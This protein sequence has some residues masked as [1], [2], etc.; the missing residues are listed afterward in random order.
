M[1]RTFRSYESAREIYFAEY[2]SEQ[3]II[4]SA[5]ERFAQ[6]RTF[7]FPDLAFQNAVDVLERLFS[8]RILEL[9]TVLWSIGAAL[10]EIAVAAGYARRS[11]EDYNTGGR[12]DDGES[13][14]GRLDHEA[15]R[16]ESWAYSVLELDP[17]RS[18]MSMIKRAYKGLMLR[19]HPDVNPRGLDKAKEINRAYSVLLE[20]VWP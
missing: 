4:R 11:G 7:R 18:D 5:S 16:L 15:D 9:E 12:A 6:D 14:A 13:T 20:A 1:L 19:Y 2:F 17:E 8:R 10:F 3:Q